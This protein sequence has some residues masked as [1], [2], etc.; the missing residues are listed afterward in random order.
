[1]GRSN[2]FRSKAPHHRDYTS[3][4]DGFVL[5]ASVI[6]GAGVPR[7]PIELAV[8]PLITGAIYWLAHVYAETVRRGQIRGYPRPSVTVS[9]PVLTQALAVDECRVRETVTCGTHRV[10]LADVVHAEARDG[11]PLAYFRGKFGRFEHA[12]HSSV[13]YRRNS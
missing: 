13:A 11:A 10:F 4:V 2:P 12:R 5:A 7:A 6:I 1:M 9:A 3:A 8:D